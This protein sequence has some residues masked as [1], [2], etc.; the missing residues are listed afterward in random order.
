MGDPKEQ[1]V[2]LRGAIPT[3]DEILQAL[4]ESPLDPVV[5][6]YVRDHVSPIEVLKALRGILG[7]LDRTWG[8][9][10][11]IGI[12]MTTGYYRTLQRERIAI[13]ADQVEDAYTEDPPDPLHPLGPNAT[14]VRANVYGTPCTIHGQS[15]AYGNETA[16]VAVYFRTNRWWRLWKEESL[17]SAQSFSW[18]FP[19]EDID[20][21]NPGLFDLKEIAAVGVECSVYL[22]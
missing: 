6:Q 20:D 15:Q 9:V 2:A 13:P 5:E 12:D 10:E 1:L 4:G 17:E 11:P 14:V 7:M 16:H 19:P 22:Y 18:I 21:V 8:D 3:F